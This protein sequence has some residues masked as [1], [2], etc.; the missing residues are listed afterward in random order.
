MVY[1]EVRSLASTTAIGGFIRA[2]DLWPVLPPSVVLS[3][4]QVSGQYYLHQWFYQGVRSL[5]STTSISGFLRRT[6]I[7]GFIRPVLYS[8]AVSLHI[9]DTDRTVPVTVATVASLSVQPRWLRSKGSATRAEGT[10]IISR[11]PRPSHSSDWYS[12]GYPPLVSHTSERYSGGYPSLVSH[13]SDRYSGGYPPLMSHTSDWYSGGCPRSSHFSD[14]YSGGCPPLVS[15]N[16]DRCSGGCPPW[17]V[18][19]VIGIRVIGIRVA[20]PG[21]VTQ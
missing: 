17:W 18:I 14:W 8:S 10:G 15:H 11:C 20:V 3:G 13:T 19:P 16:S 6:S 9:A 5:A 21:R 2:S 12:V 1:K 4:R 7:S